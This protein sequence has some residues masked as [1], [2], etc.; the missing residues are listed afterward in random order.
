MRTSPE[1]T[2]AVHAT[3]AVPVR[4][5]ATSPRSPRATRRRVPISPTAHERSGSDGHGAGSVSTSSRTSLV[6]VAVAVGAASVGGAPDESD[7]PSVVQAA[8]SSNTQERTPTRVRWKA[9]RAF[10]ARTPSAPA[11]PTSA[12]TPALPSPCHLLAQDSMGCSPDW[13]G[14]FGDVAEHPERG[15]MG[16]I[17][18]RGVGRDDALV[19][20]RP[21]GHYAARL[22]QC[23]SGR[24]TSRDGGTPATST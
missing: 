18:G 3:V 21:P 2:A 15:G 9:C 22:Q 5:T 20:A 12:R 24:G 13:P 16:H 17:R 6:V 8:W 19:E 23:A 4:L 14:H 11:G 10:I 7:D 1:S